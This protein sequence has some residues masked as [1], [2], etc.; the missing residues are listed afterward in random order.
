METWHLCAVS[1]QQTPVL[2]RP[3][4]PA[5]LVS[6]PPSCTSCGQSTQVGAGVSFLTCDATTGTLGEV[7]LEGPPTPPLPWAHRHQDP[8]G[9]FVAVLQGTGH[10]R[11][12]APRPGRPGATRNGAGA[13]GRSGACCPGGAGGT[14]DTARPPTL[15]GPQKGEGCP[16]LLPVPAPPAWAPAREAGTPKAL[17]AT[18]SLCLPG[19]PFPRSHPLLQEGLPVQVGPCVLAA[20]WPLFHI[21]GH[22]CQFRG[23]N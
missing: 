2:Q 14:R 12:L 6:H 15:M 5:R 1:R 9:L 19:L 11:C 17:L 8:Q 16:A 10:S 22:H 20:H 7:E 23:L 13:G 3:P 4:R 21:S 18:P